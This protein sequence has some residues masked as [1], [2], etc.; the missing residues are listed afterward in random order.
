MPGLAPGI[1][2]LL[3]IAKTWMAGI[4]PGHDG[5]IIAS[6]GGCYHFLPSL[7]NAASATFSA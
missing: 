5:R 1:H 6:A 4:K 3:T 2:V 7:L